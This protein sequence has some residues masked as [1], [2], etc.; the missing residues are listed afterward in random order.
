MLAHYSVGL[1]SIHA[2]AAASSNA[3]WWPMLAIACSPLDAG[4]NDVMIDRHNTSSTADF[5][6]KQRPSMSKN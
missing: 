4:Q 3:Y 5:S 1:Q 6:N 2:A